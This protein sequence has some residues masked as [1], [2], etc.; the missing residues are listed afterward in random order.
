M[1]MAQARDGNAGG[2]TAFQGNACLANDL[3]LDL[4]VPSGDPSANSILVHANV[5][6][7]YEVAWREFA[8]GCLRNRFPKHAIALVARAQEVDVPGLAVFAQLE[9]DARSA[10]E[11]AFAALEECTIQLR[12]H[13]HHFDVRGVLEASLRH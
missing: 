13:G 8:Q 12:Q 11:I 5:A 4:E 9:D 1:A 10:A 6:G 7:E 3:E 2:L